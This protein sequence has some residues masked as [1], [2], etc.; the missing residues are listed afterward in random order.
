M[1]VSSI[2]EVTKCQIQLVNFLI[3]CPIGISSTSERK[4]IFIINSNIS[5]KT[6]HFLNL[7]SFIA[8]AIFIVVT[9]LVNLTYYQ[10]SHTQKSFIAMFSS[11][12]PFCFLVTM[13]SYRNGNDVVVLL[14]M[15]LAYERKNGIRIEIR[16]L[17]QRF[18]YYF[19]VAGLF[20]ASLCTPPFMIFVNLVDLRAPPFLGSILP[21]FQGKHLRKEI[22][23][24]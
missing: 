13:F 24:F 17:K 2:I 15:L 1:A 3:H 8:Y 9:G 22:D 11:G 4:S 16:N 18:I 7:T 23:E 5:K 10:V 20:G 21:D 19:W 12:I 14:N 6:K